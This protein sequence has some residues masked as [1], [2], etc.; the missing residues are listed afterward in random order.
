MR[1]L[2]EKVWSMHETTTE[3]LRQSNIEKWLRAV[4]YLGPRWIALQRVERKVA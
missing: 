4:E 1:A 3:E 2:A